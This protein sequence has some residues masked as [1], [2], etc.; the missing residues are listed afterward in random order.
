MRKNRKQQ[1]NRNKGQIKLSRNAK[2]GVQLEQI[3][4]D[5]PTELRELR[6]YN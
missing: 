2:I 3:L 1:K 6:D 5:Q 4:R